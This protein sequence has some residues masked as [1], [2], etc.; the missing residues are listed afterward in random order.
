MISVPD[1][2]LPPSD[3]RKQPTSHWYP[4]ITSLR[5]NRPATG[6]I[7]TARSELINGLVTDGLAL[8]E[9]VKDVK[10]DPEQADAIGLLGVVTGQDVEPD[11]GPRRPM[12]DSSTCGPKD[13]TISTVDPEARHGHKTRTRKRDG[14]KAHVAT[15]PETGLVTAAVT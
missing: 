11:P 6:R 7:P 8:I 9:A 4:M 1:K 13:R 5:P 2:A 10:L 12:A 15:E 14:Y 3:T